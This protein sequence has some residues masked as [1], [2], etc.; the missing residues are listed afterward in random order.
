MF[1]VDDCCSFPLHILTTDLVHSQ[2]GTAQ[3]IR[4]LNRLG[5]CVSLDTLSRFIQSKVEIRDGR[6]PC[7]SFFTSNAFTVVSVDNIDFLHSYAQIF[8]GKQVSSWHGTSVQVVQPYPSLDVIHSSGAGSI[9]EEPVGQ[10]NN[11][12]LPQFTPA[13]SSRKRIER[14]SPLPSPLKLTQSP[15]AKH[16]RRARTEVEKHK[17]ENDQ[18]QAHSISHFDMHVVP[19]QSLKEKSLKD[20]MLNQD[21][22]EALAELQ[23]DLFAYMIQKIAVSKQCTKEKNMMN[24]Q[25][26]FT[27]I[28]VTHTE[29]SKFAYLDVINAVADSKDTI[30]MLLNDLY[31]KFIKEKGKEYLVIEGDQKLYETIQSLKA[32]YG[33]ALSWVICIPGDWHM[34]KNFQNAI[35]KPYFE[36][37]LKALAEAAGYPVASIKSCGQFK[38]T[39]QFMLESWEA[40][41]RTMITTFIETVENHNTSLQFIAQEFVSKQTAFDHQAVDDVNKKIEPVISYFFSSFKLFIQKQARTDETWRFWTQFVHQDFSAYLGLF[42]SI[43]GADWSLRTASVKEMIPVFTAFDHIHYTKLISRHLADLICMPESLLTMFRHGAFVVS[44]KGRS[45]H[46]VAIDEAHEML[47]NKACKMCVVRTSS[48]YVSRITRYLPYRS[49]VIENIN[50]NFFQKIK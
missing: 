44:I 28:R 23:H 48:D 13:P 5:V 27:L 14:S 35:M 12:N 38:R 10:N 29:K 45:L 7:E 6:H 11:D 8:N 46:S 22:C 36:A 43:R 34:L 31:T 1:C 49:M 20:F 2:G 39:H 17:D 19:Q 37:G 26:Y 32:E 40:I 30:L 9:A 18:V 42:L 50:K 25:D 15:K 3:L 4:I 16:Q 47:I 21:E 41:F 33:Q 24:I